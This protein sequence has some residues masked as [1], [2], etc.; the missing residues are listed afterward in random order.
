MSIKPIL[1]KT[2]FTGIGL[3]S[4]N[5]FVFKFEILFSIAFASE[6][7]SRAKSHNLDIR[8]GT[9]LAVTE[10]FPW[11]PFR[12]KSVAVASSPEYRKKVSSLINFLSV[13]NLDRS[14][15]ASLIPEI[16]SWGANLAI[17]SGYKSQLVLPGTL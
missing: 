17:V 12:I 8:P 7:F 4:K 13:F 2:H 3:D 15:V 9:T 5:S 11:P 14:P 6:D 1:L 16:F 10:I